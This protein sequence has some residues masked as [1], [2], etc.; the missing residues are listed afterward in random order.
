[1][2]TTPAFAFRTRAAE[3]LPI[4]ARV[5]RARRMPR[6]KGAALPLTSLMA[7]RLMHHEAGT[8]AATADDLRRDGFTEVEIRQ[9]GDEARDIAAGRTVLRMLDE[10]A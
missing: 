9:H 8:G 4:Q 5:E 6:A 3:A 10:A 2:S 7:D 1:M